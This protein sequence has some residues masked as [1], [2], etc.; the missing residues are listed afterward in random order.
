MAIYL[1]GPIV[2][3][4]PP[5]GGGG[6]TGEPKIAYSALQNISSW[7]NPYCKLVVF[8]NPSDKDV[9]FTLSPLKHIYIG[10]K[11]YNP[12]GTVKYKLKKSSTRAIAFWSQTNLNY[13]F[14][15]ITDNAGRSKV[16]WS[17]YSMTFDKNNTFLT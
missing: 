15:D 4:P 17:L 11:L 9:E 12:G 5:P 3:I 7:S 1:P 8:I 10:K 13:K 14:F 6:F 2:N 16:Y